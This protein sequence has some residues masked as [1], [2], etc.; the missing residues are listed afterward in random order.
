MFVCTCG[1]GIEIRMEYAYLRDVHVAMP[2]TKRPQHVSVDLG[3]AGSIQ[4]C[5][6][7]TAICCR[8]LERGVCSVCPH[9][10]LV[11]IE[12]LSNLTKLWSVS[13]DCL[14]SEESILGLDDSKI[15]Q[16]E[17]IF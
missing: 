9:F 8:M 4:L 12:M 1:F 10:R 15:F 2:N 17:Y 16:F 6:T 3:S 13:E 7:Q 11:L 5:A 14:N